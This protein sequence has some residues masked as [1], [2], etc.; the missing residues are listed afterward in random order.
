MVM[1]DYDSDH[2][3]NMVGA[4]ITPT[5]SGCNSFTSGIDH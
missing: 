4:K 5:V 3:T 1:T 2:V